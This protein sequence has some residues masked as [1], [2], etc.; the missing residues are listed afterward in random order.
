MSVL[1]NFDFLL[2][3]SILIIALLGLAIVWSVAPAFLA[4]QLIFFLLGLLAFF[5]FSLTDYRLFKNYSW[6]IYL[7]VLIFLIL[8][9]VFGE[10]TRGAVRWFQVGPVTV[11]PSEIAKPLLILFL[12]GFLSRYKILSLA[13]VLLPVFLIFKQPDL[14][15][16]LVVF[17]ICLGILFALGARIKW[18]VAGSL[19]LVMASP[20]VWRS[21]ADYQKQRILS[22]VNSQAD[23]LG[24]GYN[25]I[26]SVIAIGSGMIFGR[27][28]GRG[29]QSHLYFLPERHTDFIFAS[30]AEELGLLGGLLLLALYFWLFLR[31]LKI[32][33]LA[34]DNFGFLVVSGVFFFLFSQV[35]INIGMNLGILPITGIPLP[36]VSTG[37]S[38]L[39]ATMISLGLVESVARQRKTEEGI[40]IK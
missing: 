18:L 33:G 19:L 29:T 11:Q 38:S 26:Q 7:V 4:S 37:G 32:A 3:L 14:G 27:G 28:L 17:A 39:L 15:S 31:I 10:V 13:L 20:L 40:R 23:P 30:L 9:F 8:P 12:A 36:L 24:S 1:K 22:F 2:L 5:F 35:F 25:L 16:T 21:L 6:L 34:E